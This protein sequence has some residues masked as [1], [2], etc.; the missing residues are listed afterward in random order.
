LLLR[1]DGLLLLRFAERALLALL[2][3]DPPRSTRLD[4][5]PGPLAR[6]SDQCIGGGRLRRVTVT[7][8]VG[9]GIQVNGRRAPGG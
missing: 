1:L 3:H 7:G 5:L 2:F 8:H 6:S 9:S 4:L